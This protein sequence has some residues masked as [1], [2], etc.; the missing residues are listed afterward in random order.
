[1]SGRIVSRGEAMRE[2]RKSYGLSQE[3]LAA[4]AG[5]HRVTLARLES[6]AHIGRIDIIEILADALGI[7]IDV[8][9]GHRVKR[10]NLRKKVD[11]RLKKPEDEKRRKKKDGRTDVRKVRR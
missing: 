5:I 9:T 3:K 2:V 1:M 8:Y 11:Q 6:G 10:K 4:K 7:S